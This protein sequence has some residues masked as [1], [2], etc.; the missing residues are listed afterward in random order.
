MDAIQLQWVKKWINNERM[1]EWEWRGKGRYCIV[2]ANAYSLPEGM[3]CICFA[4]GIL[5][6]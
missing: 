3:Q 6:F 5:D 2:V 1:G 4:K